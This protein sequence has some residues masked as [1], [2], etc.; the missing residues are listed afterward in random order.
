MHELTFL[1]QK[2]LT[3]SVAWKYTYMLL[4]PTIF[5]VGPAIL[6]DSKYLNDYYYRVFVLFLAL[7][8]IIII[9]F[10]CIDNQQYLDLYIT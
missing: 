6:P 2:H 3:C 10:K 1:H 9:F 5:Y 7:I 4:R 8:V